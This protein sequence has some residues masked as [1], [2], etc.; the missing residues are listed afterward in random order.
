M[1]SRCTTPLS[2]LTVALLGGM[3]SG[4]LAQSA[5]HRSAGTGDSGQ[6]AGMAGQAG[7]RRQGPLYRETPSRYEGYSLTA[8]LAPVGELAAD[9]EIL[10]VRRD[11]YREQH[12]V[13]VLPLARGLIAFRD[14]DHPQWRPVSEGKEGFSPA[15]VLTWEGITGAE[16]GRPPWLHQLYGIALPRPRTEYCCRQSTLLPAPISQRSIWS[17]GS[18]PRRRSGGAARC[19]ISPGSSGARSPRSSSTS[20]QRSGA[21]C[22]ARYRSVAEDACARRQQRSRLRSA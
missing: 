15:Y 9:D 11:G 21:T 14:V 4:A 10:F 6:D 8:V 16:R 7:R 1:R 18:A 3:N 2:W 17:S 22:A 13:K 5:R 12:P 19:R 20:R